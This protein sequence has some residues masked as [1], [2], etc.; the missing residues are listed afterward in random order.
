MVKITENCVYNN[1]VEF[2]IVLL[3]VVSVIEQVVDHW[4]LELETS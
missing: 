3:R 4:N 2:E 1:D